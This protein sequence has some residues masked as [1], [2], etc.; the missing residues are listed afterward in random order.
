MPVNNNSTI[1]LNKDLSNFLTY[2]VLHGSH[3]NLNLNPN[4]L[5]SHH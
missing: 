1:H 3:L 2:I 5:L 4:P